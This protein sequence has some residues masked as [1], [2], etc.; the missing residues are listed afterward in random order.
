M[1]SAPARPHLLVEDRKG[2]T[3]IRLAGAGLSL[4]EE[5]ALSLRRGLFRLLQEG[6]RRLAVDLGNV[7]FL[8]STAVEAFLAIHRG[9]A[10]M[11][12]RLS[13][14]NPTPGVAEV[15]EVLRLTAFG[16]F[17]EMAPSE[18]ESLRLSAG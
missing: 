9:L 8:T 4:H 7:R 16:W 6:H 12:G 18:Q 11:G 17:E 1:S 10:A 13:L 2:V 3:L 15:F 5:D 14:H